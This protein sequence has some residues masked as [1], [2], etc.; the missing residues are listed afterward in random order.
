MYLQSQAPSATR[1][2]IASCRSYDDSGTPI[3]GRK[4]SVT[5]VRTTP[6]AFPLSV[7]LASGSSAAATAAASGSA[8]AVTATSDDLPGSPSSVLTTGSVRVVTGRHLWPASPAGC[9][10]APSGGAG[11]GTGGGSVGAGAAGTSRASLAGG[12]APA[13]AAASA[14]ASAAGADAAGEAPGAGGSPPGSRVGAV[15]D[16]AAAVGGAA[17]HAA[18]VLPSPPPHR[19]RWPVASATPGSAPPTLPT[20][21]SLDATTLSRA[22][23]PILTGAGAGAGAGASAGVGA[24]AGVAAAHVRPRAP[25]DGADSTMTIEDMEHEVGGDG[26]RRLSVMITRHHQRMHDVIDHCCKRAS[27]SGGSSELRSRKRADSARMQM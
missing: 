23:T 4:R 13:A 25:S 6:S 3:A 9:S 1:R 10:V 16:G 26:P 19:Q 22:S 27:V 2:V 7:S 15:I 12:S 21:V 5:L 20:P 11:G 17:L 18:P 14:A 8:R 24:G